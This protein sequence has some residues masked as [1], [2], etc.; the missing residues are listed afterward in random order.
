MPA[1]RL[2]VIGL[3]SVS[4]TLLNHFAAACPAIHRLL[5]RGVSG[6]AIPCFPVYTPTNWAALATGA[7]P[8]VTATA[9]W[10]NERFGEHLST[11]DRRAIPCDTIFDTASR[12]GRHSLAI[13][14][15]GA[16]PPASPRVQTLAPLDRGL[17]SNCLVPGK[18]LAITWAGKEAFAFPLL[19]A[20]GATSGAAA[21]K[22]VGATED[23]GTLAGSERQA[24]VQDVGATLRRAGR[25]WTLAVDGR[26]G[27]PL[28]LAADTWSAPLA[29]RVQVPGRPGR[30]VLRVMVFD[31]G[32][33]LAVSELYDVGA[34]G[35]PSR[36][37]RQVLAQ[38]GPPTEHSVFYTQT[39]A[40]FNHQRRD[41][42]MTARARADL[43]AQAD[44]IVAA[45]TLAH[46]LQPFDVFYHH[47]HYPDNAL[48]TYLQPLSGSPAFA[49]A[50][51][52]AARAA[53]RLC[54]G[55]CDRLVGGLLRLAGPETTVLLVSDHG[56]VP[57]R[58][59]CNLQ[60][61][62]MDTGLLALMPDGSIDWGETIAYPGRVGTWINLITASGSAYEAAQARVVDALLD[63]KTP[64]GERVVALALRRKDAHLLG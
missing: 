33:R 4:L 32:R 56:N 60:R 7:G 45:A 3:D 42:A 64:A 13:A 39:I 44:W 25:G 29:L 8:A 21:A 22:A 40:D 24:A 53:M 48:H 1:P 49:P 5:E 34:L 2:M 51:H 26:R 35:T 43:E 27:A 20:P 61:R 12:L 17:A 19:R 46:K 47:F 9:G 50:Q 58:Y 57:N 15:P 59:K 31:R 36:L 52:K 41:A 62:L 16:H 6:R 11:F 38:L 18:I 37:A 28:A 30:G 10:H 54:L 55:V 23:G 63:W 14:Y